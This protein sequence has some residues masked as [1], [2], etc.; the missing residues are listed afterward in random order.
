MALAHKAGYVARD[1]VDRL[2]AIQER[3]RRDAAETRAKRLRADSR[4][5]PK[6]AAADL[7]NLELPQQKL[8]AGELADYIATRDALLGLYEDPARIL[9]LAGDNGPGKTYLGSALVNHFCDRG[10]PA[11]FVTA[12]GYYRLLVSHTFGQFGRTVEDFF[13]QMHGLRLLV[14]DEV[15]KRPEK[16]YHQIELFDLINSRYSSDVATLLIT[17]KT[18]AQLNGTDGGEAYFD[19]WLRDRI[20]DGGAILPCTWRSLRGPGNGGGA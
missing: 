5:W 8:P 13:Q 16:P 1:R 20:R 15:E 4:V 2:E 6:Y 10:R 18:P 11:M 7:F 19:K 17:N 3:N 12:V 9:V 14:V